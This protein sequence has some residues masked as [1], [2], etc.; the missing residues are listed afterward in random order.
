MA[1]IN[2]PGRRTI[3]LKGVFYFVF[4]CVTSFQFS[5]YIYIVVE[6]AT[7]VR[8]TI[9]PAAPVLT[10]FKGRGGEG[11]VVDVGLCCCSCLAQMHMFYSLAFSIATAFVFFHI[12]S[13]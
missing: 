11:G 13:K 4:K 10:K 7:W 12:F 2:A 9:C 5:T 3:S 8:P 6:G 1:I